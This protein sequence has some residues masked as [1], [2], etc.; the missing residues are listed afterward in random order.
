M[1]CVV[2]GGE[3]CLWCLV[4]FANALAISYY[5]NDLITSRAE[6]SKLVCACVCAQQD[7]AL[8]FTICL[9]TLGVQQTVFLIK[10]GDKVDVTNG[11]RMFPQVV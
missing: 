8:D 2:R 7:L 3:S 4:V 1:F 10:N 6:I 5:N 11:N 9:D